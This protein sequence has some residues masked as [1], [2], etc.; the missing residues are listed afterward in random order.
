MGRCF[1]NITMSG[2]V[3]LKLAREMTNAILSPFLAGLSAC[4]C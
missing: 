1:N 3:R 2:L 4:G